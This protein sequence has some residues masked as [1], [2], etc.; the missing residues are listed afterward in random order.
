MIFC[1][2][3]NWRARVSI[4]TLPSLLVAAV[5]TRPLVQAAAAA[6]YAV[7][8][9]DLFGDA[10]VRSHAASVLQLPYLDG[11]FAPQAFRYQVL[12]RLHA[13]TAFVYGGGF[14]THPEL[15][16]EVAQHCELLGNTAG[17]VRAVKD[18]AVFFGFLAQK[19]IP[20]PAISLTPPP[21]AQGWL[22][23]RIGGSGGMHIS[24]Q[25]KDGPCYWQRAARGVPYSLLFLADGR[26][27]V[28]I[29]YHR[30]WLA[31]TAEAPYRYGGAV[32]QAGLPESLRGALLEV[33]QHITGEF[34]LRGLN[35]L[36]CLVE[37]AG[38]LVLEINPR[39]GASFMLYDVARAGAELFRLHLQTCRGGPPASLP[40]EPASAH[41]IYYAPSD[42][43][44]PPTI[45]WPSWV[46]DRPEGG[47]N[48]LRGV[49]LCT[50]LATAENE[51]DA[52]TIAR[53]RYSDLSFIFSEMNMEHKAMYE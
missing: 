43:T 45:S 47:S 27:A 4:N 36:D 52:E 12:P 13:A 31:P 30:Q 19:K 34:G 14:E 35:S 41:L 16:D 50:V 11:G 10:D 20:F 26:K 40:P 8:A 51:H 39:P 29:G 21:D 22:C 53:R 24:P 49:P 42:L 3:S 9:A 15:L 37:G 5:S 38:F 1:P 18:P 46:A 23:K 2:H 44:L 7:T 33:A 6:G 32:S 48:I 17:T 28:A 25:S